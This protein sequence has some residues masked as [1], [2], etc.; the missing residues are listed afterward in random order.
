[1]HKDNLAILK[2]LVE[3]I[4]NVN[5]DNSYNFTNLINKL[6]LDRNMVDGILRELHSE[7]YIEYGAFNGSNYGNVLIKIKGHRAVKG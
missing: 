1:M 5:I 2:I 6:N 3:E 4:P 7:G